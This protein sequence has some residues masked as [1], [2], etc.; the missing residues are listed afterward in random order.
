MGRLA[1]E[2]KKIFFQEYI[3]DHNLTPRMAF[4]VWLVGVQHLSFAN[5]NGTID[6]EGNVAVS[7]VAITSR[8]AQE[9]NTKDGGCQG[10]FRDLRDRGLRCLTDRKSIIRA[11]Q[12]LENMGIVS[13][14][15]EGHGHVAVGH[16]NLRA[17]AL[18]LETVHPNW[19]DLT[20]MVGNLFNWLK[21]MCD[22]ILGGHW[23]R[24]D[25]D[26]EVYD[27]AYLEEDLA[28]FEEQSGSSRFDFSRLTDNVWRLF[29][30]YCWRIPQL[31]KQ[32]VVSWDVDISNPPDYLFA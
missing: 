10:W 18:F 2:A 23:N 20:D 5:R 3:L 21:P 31:F 32:R 13:Y 14:D 28:E 7:A 1:D 19:E 9:K 25:P 11:E 12:H 17:M 8:E 22:E 15:R 30:K 6:I 4:T 29:K 24:K 27:M 26:G 16:I